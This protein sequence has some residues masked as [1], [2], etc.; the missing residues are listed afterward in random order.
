METTIPSY[1]AIWFSAIAAVYILN[2]IWV[3][4]SIR[5]QA[6]RAGCKPAFVRRSRWPL[7]ID[8]LTRILTAIKENNL[9]NDD[10]AVYE[11]MGC[12]ST[13]VQSILGVWYHTTVDPENIKAILATQFKDFELGPLRFN[14]LAPL[15]GHGIFTS[16]GKDWCVTHF[17]HC[18]SFETNTGYL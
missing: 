13:W 2:A 18:T 16:D 17:I 7:G 5:I 4:V 9:Q 8:N 10:I 15:V 1:A 3:R 14:Q 11:E 12:P 6:Q